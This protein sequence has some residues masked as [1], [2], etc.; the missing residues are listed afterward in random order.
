MNRAQLEKCNET[1]RENKR[2]ERRKQRRE[3]LGEDDDDDNLI[4]W[5]DEDC[6]S[7]NTNAVKRK[8]DQKAS[9]IICMLH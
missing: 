4:E 1:I 7:M 2:F 3:Q 5:M 8:L 9:K 6:E